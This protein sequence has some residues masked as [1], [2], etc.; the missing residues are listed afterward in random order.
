MGGHFSLDQKLLAGKDCLTH[1]C[2][3]H[4]QQYWPQEALYENLLAFLTKASGGRSPPAWRGPWTLE[5]HS[6]FPRLFFSFEIARQ[7]PTSAK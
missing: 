3:Q 2:L 6:Y 1:H 5:P 4:L 7:S